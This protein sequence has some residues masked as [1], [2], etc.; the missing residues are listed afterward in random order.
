MTRHYPDL[1]SASDWL[2]QISHA[3]WPIR[4]TTQVWI[5]TRLQNGISVLVSQTR[6]Y[7]AE[8]PVVVSRNV[9]S[10]WTLLISITSRCS[11][12]EP[13]CEWLYLVQ[14]RPD[15]RLTWGFYKCQ[16]PL[17]DYVGLEWFTSLFQS[18]STG[19]NPG[20]QAAGSNCQKLVRVGKDR[21]DF[22]CF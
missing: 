7:F 21:T 20:T 15:E 18:S 16:F 14:Y 13:P 8:K 1:G 6:R 5:V 19:Q 12:N 9:G 4:S 22:L 10:G 3:A 2:N 17:C 11:R